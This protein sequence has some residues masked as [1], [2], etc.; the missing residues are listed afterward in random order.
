MSGL[1]LVDDKFKIF[2]GSASPEL[3][4]RICGYLGVKL[5]AANLGR[6]S[7]GEMY[8]QVLE[9]VRGADVFVVQPCSEPVDRHILELLLMIDAFK[10]ASAWRVTAVVPYYA[11]ARQDRKDKPRVPISAK[12][13]A[14]LLETAGASRALT[15]DLHAPQIQGYFNVPVDHLYASPVLIEYFKG[16]KLPNITVVSPDAGGVERARAFA[17][18]L[19]APLAIVDKRRVDV[20]VSEVMHLI[21]DVRGKTA[22]V[23]DDIIDT[24]GTLVKTAEA[25]MKEGAT[26]VFAACTHAVLSG[27]AV[28]RLSNSAISEVVV[29]DSVPLSEAG[30]K[31]SKIKVLS[32]ADLLAR[33]IRSIH[34][35]TSISELF[36]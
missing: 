3:A 11:Y 34:E 21:G 17:K 16:R 18:K 31:L 6:F 35:E 32:V 4:R 9:N 26:Q 36:E 8:F 14:D 7:D 15:L 12:L 28:E 1:D 5:G 20:D 30:R 22:L 24:A 25:L 10:R 33:G 29:T 19:D 27:P 13:V 23:V 2:C